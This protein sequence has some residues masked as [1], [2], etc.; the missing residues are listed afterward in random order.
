VIS[1]LAEN[2]FD[3]PQKKYYIVIDRLDEDWVP[4]DR[5]R[6]KLIKAL[7]ETIR[8]FR[9]VRSVKII[10]ALRTDLH[11]RVLR[12]T[13]SSGFQDEKY[14]ALYLPL[15]WTRPQIVQLLNDRVRFMFKRQYTNQSGQLQDVLPSNQIDKRTAA[16]YIV[17]RT[18]FRPREAIL[19]LNECLAKSEGASRITI[20]ILRQ[21]EVTYSQQRLTSLADEWRQDY[22]NL[23]HASKLLEH[24]KT[25]FTV[26]GLTHGELEAVAAH[27]IER[28]KTK[29]IITKAA[30]QFFYND[31]NHV[32]F[33]ECLVR[34][35]YQ[36]GLIGVK[37]DP[38]LGRQWS[39]LDQPTLEQ[40]Q[41][42]ST[43][44]IDIHKTFWAVLGASR[45]P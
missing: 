35:F 39:Y 44:Q 18:F 5:I 31:S 37:P 15:R 11:E 17:D 7:I 42:K 33:A 4:D 20:Q 40:G 22:P 27:V 8:T 2:I 14:R 28:A 1:L 29:D 9:R 12:G 26:E 34:V 32:S 10:I 19:F 16:E 25:P 30:E 41:V 21:A 43:S 13:E 24:R 3:D 38:H 45:T 36:V 23:A 6:L